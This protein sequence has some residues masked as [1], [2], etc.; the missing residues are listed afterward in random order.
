MTRHISFT[1]VSWNNKYHGT[2]YTSRM[3]S[4]F[5][6]TVPYHTITTSYVLWL[7]LYIGLTFHYRILKKIFIA[8]QMTFSVIYQRNS[9]NISKETADLLSTK[10]CFFF[11]FFLFFLNPMVKSPQ[12]HGLSHQPYTP[13][14]KLLYLSNRH[15]GTVLAEINSKT[16]GKSPPSET[17][18]GEYP[19]E[20]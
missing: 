7:R 5:I 18:R 11:F 2:G 17:Q 12:G 14:C 20:K 10:R 6:D 19:T 4:G 8:S 1:G 3:I 15:P 9:T 13:A 16:K